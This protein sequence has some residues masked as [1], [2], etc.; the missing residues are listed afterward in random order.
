MESL[1]YLID[2]I[3]I[4][5]PGSLFVQSINE[6]RLGIHHCR[7][8]QILAHSHKPRAARRA[9]ASKKVGFAR[10]GIAEQHDVCLVHEFR[11]VRGRPSSG[12]AGG[13]SSCLTSRSSNIT[14]V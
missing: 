7:A 11:K 3:I 9:E 5:P 12:P 2:Y 6:E 14:R 4:S 1:H 10:S 13:G 8:V